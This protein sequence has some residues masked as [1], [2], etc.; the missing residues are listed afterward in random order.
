MGFLG[1]SLSFSTLTCQVRGNQERVV[2]LVVVGGG[3]G[4]GALKTNSIGG[5]RAPARE[6]RTGARVLNKSKS[7]HLVHQQAPPHLMG[8]K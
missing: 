3:G 1:V 7:F 8:T 2:V 4:G 6:V 5:R